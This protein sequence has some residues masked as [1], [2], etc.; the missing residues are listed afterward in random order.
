MTLPQDYSNI[1]LQ[2]EAHEVDEHDDLYEAKTTEDFDHHRNNNRL[3]PTGFFKRLIVPSN[4]Y[5]PSSRE[6]IQRS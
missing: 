1:D 4:R 2:H 5:T 6:A 3:S